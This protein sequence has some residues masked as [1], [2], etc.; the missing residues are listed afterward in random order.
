MTPTPTLAEA[1]NMS[2]RLRSLVQAPKPDISFQL[3]SRKKTYTTLDRIEGV[4]TVVAPVDTNFDSVEIEFI[5]TS[6]TFVER[7]T[8]A[9]AASG[10]SEAFHQFL[11]LSQPGLHELYPEDLVLRAGQP[12]RFPFVFAIPEQLLPRICSHKVKNEAVRQAHLRLPPTFG[13]RDLGARSADNLDDIAPDMASIRYGIFAKVTELRVHKENVWRSTI[14]SKARRVRVIPAVEEQPPL[15]VHEDEGEYLMRRERAIRKSL[16]KGKTGTLVM[17]A[18]Q[19]PALAVRSYNNP[20]SKVSTTATVML[21]YDPVDSASP[22]PKLGNLASKLKVTTYFAS[23]ARSSLPARNAAMLDLSSGAHS[24]QFLLSSRCIANVEW[25]K[26]EP[27]NL[28]CK[29]D[30]ERR[31]SANST[32]SL[33]LG[34]VPAPSTRYQGG[35][36]YT[37]RLVV[38]LT[39]P[40]NK[41]FVPTF[42]SCLVSRIYV[43]KLDLGISNAGIAPKMELK[44]PV[45]ITT[46]GLLSDESHRRGSVDSAVSLDV[47][48]DAEDVSAFF[49][50]RMVRAPSA[51]FLGRG[52]I[53]SQ[54]PVDDDAPPGYSGVP[55]PTSRAAVENTRRV[56]SVPVY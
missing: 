30:I 19:P 44:L 36:Y 54:A 53:G 22:L 3:S 12:Y 9:A 13:D 17:E 46:D 1:M 23:T 43:L 11:K 42:H 37:A 50:P 14:A 29:A 33:E 6:R 55:F 7:M 2:S 10:R 56:A 40:S 16:F 49:E 26:H 39:L 31:D 28:S 18:A 41:N 47:D 52:R 8:S 35:E 4:V 27:G 45:Q 38:P 34:E 20:E 25:T 15:D 21:R 5:G 24:E 32:N 51:G 48:L